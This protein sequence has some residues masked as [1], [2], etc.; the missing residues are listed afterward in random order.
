ME[1]LTRLDL[2]LRGRLFGMSDKKR[3]RF[4]RVYHTGR[5]EDF[6]R[7]LALAVIHHAML[8]VF[9]RF[10][11][12][13]DILLWLRESEAL[14]FWLD[15]ADIEPERFQ[16]AVEHWFGDLKEAPCTN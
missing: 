7:C 1:A 2:A 13:E 11:E 8:D 6:Y 10:E 12:W 15:A 9:N 14:E 3:E 16:D 4:P 5:I